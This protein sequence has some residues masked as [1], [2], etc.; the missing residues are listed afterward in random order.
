[1]RHLLFGN[2]ENVL[3][4]LKLRKSKK[5]S[6][7]WKARAKNWASRADGKKRAK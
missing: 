2:G 1:L 5:P 6:K 7:R 4:K 3:L